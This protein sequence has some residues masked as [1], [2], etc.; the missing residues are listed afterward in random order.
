LGFLHES[1][2]AGAYRYASSGVALIVIYDGNGQTVM[3][4]TRVSDKQLFDIAT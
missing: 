2:S 4:A 1:V 3:P